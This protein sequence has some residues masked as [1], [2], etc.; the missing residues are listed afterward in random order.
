MAPRK[1]YFFLPTLTV[2]P[3]F[4]EVVR[5]WKGP[6][7]CKKVEAH[8]PGEQEEAM[9]SRGIPVPECGEV[10]SSARSASSK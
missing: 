9:Y 1:V 8:F 4:L 3:E 5:G 10:D 7:G 2:I 6:R